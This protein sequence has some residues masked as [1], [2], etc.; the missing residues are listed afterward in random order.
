MHE[1]SVCQALLAQVAQVAAAADGAARVSHLTLEV[2]ALA[3]VD[4][5]QLA[6]AFAVMRTGGCAAQAILLIETIGVRIECLGCGTESPAAPNRLICA[7]CG[8][9]RTRVVAGEEMR[10]RRVE[11]RVES[12]RAVAA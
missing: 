1:M 2:G 8:G 7:A 9:Y 10:L 11:L 12:P 6:A 5:A 3:G 4:P